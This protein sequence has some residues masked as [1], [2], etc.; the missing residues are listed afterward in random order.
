MP[1]PITRRTLLTTT[2]AALG[3][4]LLPYP[5][6]AAAD[7]FWDLIVVGGGTAGMPTAYFASKRMRVL[8][9]EKAGILG[10]TL[11]RSTGQ[12]AAA[13]TVWQAEKGIEDSPDAHYDDIMRINHGTSDP[14]LTRRFVEHAGEALNWLARHGYE[15][16]PE[17]PVTGSGHEHFRTPRYQWGA[18]GGWSIYEA[19]LPLVEEQVRSGRLTTLMNTSVEELTLDERGAV[20]GVIARPLEREPRRIRARNVVLATGGCAGNPE[21]FEALHGVPLSCRIAHHN[22]QGIGIT[23]GESA[24]GYVRGGEHYLPLAGGVLA[25]PDMPAPLSAYAV[26]NPPAR[27]PWE[28]VVNAEGERF[29]REDHPSI[30]HIEVAVGR[31]PGETHW[32]VFDEAIL[33][34][35]PPLLKEWTRE[36]MREAVSDHPLMFRAETLGELAEA[37][38]LPPGPLAGTV[39]AYNRALAAGTPDPLGREHRPLAV[40]K[41]PFYAVRLQGWTVVSFA[42]LAVDADLRVVKRSG[43][44]V[45]NLYA[46]GEVIGAGA[47]SGNAYTNG[48]L[49][50]P[51]VT[52]GRLLGERVVGG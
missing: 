46:V 1:T 48:M 33:A 50:T 39:D 20:T 37:T 17:H 7:E 41:P 8:V 6:R 49:V 21:M 25:S 32:A 38:G 24:G 36:R 28:L 29:V 16:L 13:N 51:A 34:Q 27:P 4:G 14:A 11:D 40:A 30:H 22:A 10:G 42:G 47:T 15:V 45:A 9:I 31:Q 3:L 26:L 12:V 18:K 35:A 5:L 43:E 19:M 52:F 44:A 2:S 23:L